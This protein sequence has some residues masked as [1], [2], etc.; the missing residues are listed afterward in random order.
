MRLALVAPPVCA[1]RTS[2]QQAACSRRP[3][4]GAVVCAASKPRR[5]AQG[6]ELEEKVRDARSRRGALE[7][8][9]ALG[10]HV[11][12]AELRPVRRSRQDQ[13]FRLQRT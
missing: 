5:D 10:A 3:C 11:S 13:M 8:H 4:R 7:P 9:S 6:R 1:N 12:D 2:T